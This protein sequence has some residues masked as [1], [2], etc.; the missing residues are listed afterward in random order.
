MTSGIEALK[1]RPWTAPNL[2]TLGGYGG[3]DQELP[4]PMKEGSLFRQT[5]QM[6][7]LS[8]SSGARQRLAVARQGACSG[9]AH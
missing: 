3:T 8:G 6:P 4:T 9:A 2:I 1:T 7:N 5:Q